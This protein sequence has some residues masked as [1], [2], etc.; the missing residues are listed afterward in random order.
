MLHLTLDVGLE[1]GLE[2][3]S[4]VGLEVGSD[5]GSDVGS[6]V[7]KLIVLFGRKEKNWGEMNFQKETLPKAQ[8]TQSIESETWMIF[9]AKMNTNSIQSRR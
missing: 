7:Y 4:D 1:V 6:N 3:K 5:V 9:E 8:R 2:V